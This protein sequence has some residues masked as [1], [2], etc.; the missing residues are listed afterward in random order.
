MMGGTTAPR[1]ASRGTGGCWW[2]V[3]VAQ[4]RNHGT[5]QGGWEPPPLVYCGRW[6]TPSGCQGLQPP[7][8]LGAGEG[9]GDVPV[10]NRPHFLWEYCYRE[11]SGDVYE[12]ECA[13][14]FLEEASA[15]NGVV[16][17][18]EPWGGFDPCGGIF[19]RHL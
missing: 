10:G 14:V 1:T 2:L 13:I 11:G 4:G 15:E 9:K 18:G 3:V 12:A 8:P 5:W 19:A 17:A 6:R 7:P 16:G